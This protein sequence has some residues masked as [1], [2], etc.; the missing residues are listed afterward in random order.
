MNARIQ[1]A[2][3]GDINRSVLTAAEQAEL[4]EAEAAI[5]NVLRAVPVDALPDL[6]PAVLDRIK[7]STANPGAA[8]S[9]A[10]SRVRRPRGGALEWL[11]QPRSISIGWR[12]VYGLAAAVILVVVVTAKALRSD[13]IPLPAGQQVLTQFVLRAPDARNVSLAGDFTDWQPAYSMT[14]SDP[15]VWT[16]V[17]PLEPG[18]HQYSFVVNGERWIPD[19]AAPAVNDGF[20]GVNSRIAVLTPDGSL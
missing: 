12:P 19:P 10:E 1:A 8:S 3:D 7:S 20:G 14:R 17:V 13:G 2:L 18:V 5:E 9:P 11:W 6:R 16:V 15:G 4:L